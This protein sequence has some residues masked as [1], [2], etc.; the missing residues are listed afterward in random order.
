V[1]GRQVDLMEYMNA[2]QELYQEDRLNIRIY[3]GYDEI[4]NMDIRTGLGDNMVRYGYYK[5]FLDGS[6]GGRSAALLEPYSDEPGNS[7]VMNY[8]LDEVTEL[9]REATKRHLQVGVHAIGDRATEMLTTAIETVAAE[10]LFPDPRFRMIHIQLVNEDLI[11]RIKKLPV[12]IDTQP[13][14]IHTDLP[15]IE[16]RVG[17]ERMN[18]MNPWKRL[19]DEGM[20]LTSGSDSPGADY[21][22]WLGMHAAVNRTT[23]DGFPKGGSHMEHAVSVYEALCMYTKNAAYASFEEKDKGTIEAGKLADFIVID[24]DIVRVDTEELI[25]VKVRQTVL[26]GRT[27]Y[28][29]TQQ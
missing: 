1:Q 9:I 3:L 12:I 17:K 27:V 28:R 15:W 6:L 18:Y 8:T 2:Y 7:G 13:V 26:G 4:P 20:I 21:D 25:D 23:A 24:R 19:I 11:E 14:F 16:D 22:P 29:E 10:D 5:L